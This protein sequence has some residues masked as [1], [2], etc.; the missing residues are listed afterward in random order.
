MDKNSKTSFINNYLGITDNLDYNYKKEVKNEFVK[1]L[2]KY[3]NR[4]SEIEM[5]LKEDIG[6]YLDSMSII[7][8]GKFISVYVAK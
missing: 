5:A 6:V 4:L 8:E 1:F 2:K 7:E 3:N